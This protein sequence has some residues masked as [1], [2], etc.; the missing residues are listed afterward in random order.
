MKHG[1]IRSMN[2]GLAVLSLGFLLSALPASAAED[3]EKVQPVLENSAIRFGKRTLELPPDGLFVFKDANG[4]ILFKNSV[5]FWLNE[6]GKT[7]WLW[8][9]RNPDR[10]KSKFT[11]DGNKYT[12]EL[13]FKDQNTPSFQAITQVL[14]V[15]PDGRISN[16]VKLTLPEPTETR[17]FQ[18]WIY[19]LQLP[20]A[21]WLQETVDFNGKKQ[22]L[23]KDLKNTQSKFRQAVEWTF[24]ADNPE[25]KF[26]VRI[27]PS[28]TPQLA[29]MFRPIFKEFLLCF[30]RYKKNEL[31]NQ[32]YFDLR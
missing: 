2:T 28:G 8:Q 17:Q 6:N 12:W 10:E 22:T 14:E 7:Q 4:K 29:I 31:V 1:F 32:V 23:T 25:K 16:T 26:T 18:F 24:G 30:Q 19:A 11:R 27:E 21:S 5:S 13:W 20:E 3:S 15:L 9:K